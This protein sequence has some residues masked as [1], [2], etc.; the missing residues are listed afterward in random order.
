MRRVL[1]SVLLVTWLLASGVS[2]QDVSGLSARIDQLIQARLD[3]EGIEP[4]EIADDAEFLRRVYLDLHGV[5][6]P[7]ERVATFLASTEPQKRALLI[8]ELLSNPRYGEYFAEIWRRRLVSPIT[9]A[10][11]ATPTSRFGQWLADRFNRNVPWDRIVFD[12]VTAS[13]KIDENPSVVYLIEGRNP[14]S[15]TD[16]NDLVSRCF[17]GIRLNCAQCHDHPFTDITRQDYWGM[18]AFFV[19]I[20]TPGR[21]KQVHRVGVQDDLRLTAATLSGSDALEGFLACEPRFLKCATPISLQQTPY[22]K[23]LA[24]WLV[25]PQNPYFARAMVNRLWAHFFGRGVVNPVDDMYP[26]NLPSHPELLDAMACAF[27]TSG[28]DIKFLCRA[29]L[30]SRTYQRTSRPGGQPQRE[31]ER[32]A[33]MSIKVLTPEQLYDSLVAI[34]GFST[35]SKSGAGSSRKR[36][37]FIRYFSGEGDGD[38]TYYDR[39]IP[40]VLRLMNSPEFSDRIPDLVS[41]I[42]SS[43]NS[44]DEIIRKLFLTILSRLP[45]DHE[46]QRVMVQDANTKK[47]DKIFY[48]DLAWALLMSSEFA[49]NH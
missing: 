1:L 24:H 23:A 35:P 10:E 17:L 45:T 47:R 29:I 32:F 39:G 43:S 20:Q 14:L 15:I 44:D 2:A 28:F 22:R 5:V 13:G 25:S 34:L 27:A 36:D 26:G 19:Q 30:N 37:E 46:W 33:R 9:A 6:P 8:D 48:H 11:L 21:P 31:A 12:L 4:V 42:S 41:H 49:L 7:A 16:L 38:P 3:A 18:A 40:H